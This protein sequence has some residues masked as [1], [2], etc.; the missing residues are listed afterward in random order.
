MKEI[1]R[2]FRRGLLTP[3]EF[4]IEIVHSEFD[5]SE[6]KQLS[7]LTERMIFDREIL[8]ADAGIDTQPEWTSTRPVF[9]ARDG[10][11]R[12]GFWSQV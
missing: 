7:T 8:L 2:Q 11:L 6:W 12:F 1:I 3:K 5:E 4:A 10:V 9:E